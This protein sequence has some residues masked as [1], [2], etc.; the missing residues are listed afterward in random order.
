MA[1]LRYSIITL[2]LFYFFIDYSLSYAFKPLKLIHLKPYISFVSSYISDNIGPFTAA[3]KVMAHDN[4]NGDMTPNMNIQNSHSDSSA[5]AT[6]RGLPVVVSQDTH[7]TIQKFLSILSMTLIG[8]IPVNADTRRK[9]LNT[10]PERPTLYSIDMT[11]PPCM[12]PRTLKGEA[13]FLTRLLASQIILFG[14]HSSDA[15][16]FIFLVRYQYNVESVHI[17]YNFMYL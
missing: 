6:N 10:A 12:I 17:I 5:P 1:N 9:G 8:S 11:N 2:S 13:S 16:D 7:K 4:I 14:I 15:R 3:S